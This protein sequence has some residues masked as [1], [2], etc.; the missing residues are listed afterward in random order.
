MNHRRD[1]YCL[2]REAINLYEFHIPDMY[3]KCERIRGNYG[4]GADILSKI[5]ECDN[6]K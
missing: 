1:R 3:P 5:P 2:W 4:G 6:V